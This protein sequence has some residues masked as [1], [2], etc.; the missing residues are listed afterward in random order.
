MKRKNNRDVVFYTSN[1]SIDDA[2]HH[3]RVTFTQDLEKKEQTPTSVPS[4]QQL[5]K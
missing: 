1:I 2:L 3:I 4:H 5:N